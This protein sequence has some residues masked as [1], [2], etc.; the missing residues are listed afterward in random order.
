MG[1]KK[2]KNSLS[3]LLSFVALVA[4]VGA[5]TMMFLPSLHI[6]GTL[7][8][9][10]AGSD[11]TGL[12]TAFGYA[13]EN[14]TYFTFSF[15]NL[16]SYLMVLASVVLIAL[17]LFG[18]LKGNLVDYLCIAMLTVSGVFFFLTVQFAVMSEGLSNAISIANLARTTVTT[19]L[20]I[21]AILA[22]VFSLVSAILL[23]T[24]VFTSKK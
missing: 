19:H 11:F 10:R 6:E 7:A 12:Q 9:L 17:K 16:L 1:K 2:K 20:G 22:G 4:G 24:K 13:S 18:V 3:K 15:L 21:G 14:V 5:L 23:L 8:F